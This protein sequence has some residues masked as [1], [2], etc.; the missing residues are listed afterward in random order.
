M[1]RH[2]R[3]LSAVAA[4]CTAVL[5]LSACGAGTSDDSVNS[6]DS[7]GEPVAGGELRAIQMS[8]PRTLDPAAMSNG[9]AFQGLLGNA[10]YGMLIT[11]SVDTLEIEYSMATDFSTADG[12]KTFT[13][14]LQP[15]LTFTDGLP[16]DATAVKYNWDRLRDPALGSTS[17]RQAAQISDTEV[18]DATTLKVTMGTPNPHFP[19]SMVL[20]TMNW[21]ASPAALE[22]GQA[23][24]DAEPVGAGP[25]TLASWS[26]Q[27][28][29]ELEKN[30][31]YWDA[32]KPYL[33][34]IELRSSPDTNQRL[35]A[36]V[37]GSAD[38]TSESNWTTLTKAEDAGL[39]VETAPTGGGQYMGM[40]MRRA[41]FDDVR[42]RRAV[43]LAVDPKQINAVV[44]GDAGVDQVPTAM[45]L[46][47]S[48]FFSDIPLTRSDKNEAQKL[49]DELAAEGK[50]V[51][52]TFVGYSSAE[53]KAAGEALQAQLSAFENVD[54]KVEILDNTTAV[55]RLVNHDFDVMIS[56]ALVQDPDSALWTSFHSESSGN[57]MGIDDADLDAALDAGR[58]AQT[59]EE[60]KDAYD[61]VQERLVELSQG[62]WY[63]RGAPSV[64]VG[65]NVNGV[66][67]YSTGS[68]IPQEL[69]IAE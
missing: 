19:Q 66:E 51:S 25:F 47:A 46:E 21:I 3:I 10:L 18:I 65:Q 13:L 62:L 36:L 14:T 6:P 17:M 69:W 53:N 55:S 40:N 12:G 1:I 56:T 5:L 26:R 7:S 27:N 9:W 30:P 38:L 32:P 8:E 29:I 22:K 64:V 20:S 52:F 4:A 59:L 35:N 43:A 39:A 34:R 37:S 49:F 67:M 31:D 61:T 2:R 23:A 50:P 28:V 44:Y 63:V 16:L 58:N 42:A 48:P 41:P 45:F 24:F 68:L 11:N 54:A 57:F 60:R 15:G 33:D